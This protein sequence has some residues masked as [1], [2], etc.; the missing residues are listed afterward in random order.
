MISVVLGC[1]FPAGLAAPSRT[2]LRA[3][4]RYLVLLSL[5]LV[6][7][8]PVWPLGLDLWMSHF[9]VLFGCCAMAHEEG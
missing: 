6:L 4:L 5:D 2:L 8:S 7:L 1:R 3:P 9:L